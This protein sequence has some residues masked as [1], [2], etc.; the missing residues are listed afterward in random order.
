[1]VASY[2]RNLPDIS[3]MAD[4]QP[5][6]STRVFARDGTVLA[7]LY[8]ENRIWVPIDKSRCRSAT[9]S[10]R[11][12]TS[13]S[14]STTASISAASCAPPSPTGGTNRF[15]G[16]ST[17]TQQLARGL[18]LSDE[19]SHLA[20]DPRSAAGHRDRALLH[21]GRDPRALP[22]HHLL[23]FRRVRHR[24]RGAYLFRNR[25]RESDDRAGRDAGRHRPGAVG[26]LAVRQSRFARRSGSATC[27]TA[28]SRA[29]SSRANRRMRARA[30][31]LGLDGR[32]SRRLAIVQVSVLHDLRRRICLDEQF[33][34]QATFEGGLQV[35]TTLDPEMQTI[36]QNAVDWG[37]AQAAAEGIGA[38]QAALVAIRPSTGEILAM[39]G[40]AGRSRSTINSIAPG[41][42]AA[43]PVRRSRPTSTR[44]RSTAGCRRPTI[45]DDSPVSYPM[46]DGTQWAPQDDD[47]RFHGADHAALRAGAIAQRRSGKAGGTARHRPR[48]RVREAHG[49]EGAARSQSLAG[50]GHQR[51]LAARSGRRLRDAGRMPAFTSIRR[52]FAWCATRFGTTVLDNRIRSRPKSSARERRTS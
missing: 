29:D 7:D 44:R 20:Q 48:H 3:R 41:R 33:G 23:R 45:I 30:D 39:V 14:T 13:I 10:S 21:E 6:R 22:Q 26:L 51:R 8:K 24:S 42:R 12:K 5:E 49:R 52:R 38:H 25:R 11:P 46:G 19:V 47:H 40:G 50:A 16:A 17:I 27:S 2:S 37:V 43:S 15:Q 34:T 35:Y 4:Y 31:P 32:T 9:R 28:W 18:F 36:A 1:M